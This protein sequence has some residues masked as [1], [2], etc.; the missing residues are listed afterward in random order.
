MKL[1]IQKTKMQYAKAANPQ[2][3]RLTLTQD[4]NV[5]FDYNPEIGNSVHENEFSKK[6]FCL[7][8]PGSVPSNHI[9]KFYS[10]N[11]EL[12]EALFNGTN[13]ENGRGTL[14]EEAQNAKEMLLNEANRWW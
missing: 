1:I 11:K 14:T 13:I 9:R 3:K 5:I 2:A 10:K 6:I 7:Q 4:G 8:F 12:F